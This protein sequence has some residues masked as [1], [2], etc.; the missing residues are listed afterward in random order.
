MKQFMSHSAVRITVLLLMSISAMGFTIVFHYCTMS[1]STDCCCNVEYPEHAKAPASIPAL[2]G[3]KVDCDI[4][5]VAGGLNP[6]AQNVIPE[7]ITK[8][9]TVNFVP[10]DAGIHA[11]SII[12]HDCLLAHATDIAPPDIAI[13]IRTSSLLI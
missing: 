1:H 6:V 2:D 11:P 7:S 3:Q 12:P 5:I 8:S 13:Y 10:V 9:I 4:Q